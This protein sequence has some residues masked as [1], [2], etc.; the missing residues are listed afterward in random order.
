MTP[1]AGA[2]KGQD[3]LL[4]AL[5]DE[6]PVF[7]EVPDIAPPA[8][9]RLA[10][11]KIPRQPS[12]YSGRTAMTAQ[13]SVQEPKPPDDPDAPLAFSMEGSA[14]E[15]PSSLIPR[16]WAPQW[17]SVQAIN[18]F[19]IETGGALHGGDPGRRLIEPA[20]GKPFAYAAPIPA[21]FVAQQDAWWVLPAWHIYG[22]DELS[23]RSPGVAARAPGSYIALNP[24]DLARLGLSV[25][26]EVA[27]SIGAQSRVCSVVA[28]PCLP[29]GVAR[30][31]AG[32]PGLP[33]LALPAW[34]RIGAP[35]KGR[36]P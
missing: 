24:A 29:V 12:R 13:I 31:P 36:M 16:F 9:F 32:L 14:A 1:P 3:D 5:A 23:L 33:A 4:A 17:N 2:W 25:G 8:G 6:L 35:E 21:A 26:Q 22:S 11:R 28:A 7:R 34:G 27:L 10:G 19:Q 20:A 15:P 18:K 30:A